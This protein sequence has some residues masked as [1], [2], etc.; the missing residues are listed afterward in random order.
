[1]DNQKTRKAHHTTL[2]LSAL[3]ANLHIEKKEQTTKPQHIPPPYFPPY[4]LT[5]H[6]SNAN[7]LFVLPTSSFVLLHPQSAKSNPLYIVHCPFVHSS[8][9][10]TTY[11]NLSAHAS[12]LQPTASFYSVLRTHYSLLHTHYSVLCT[13]S[14][15]D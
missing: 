6:Y 4:R 8:M 13:L 14:H 3:R 7:P 1:M 2:L 5:P 12:D 15:M 9:P 10:L 11:Q